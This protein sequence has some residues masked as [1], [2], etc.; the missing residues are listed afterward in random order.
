MEKINLEQAPVKKTFW[1]YLM[2]ALLMMGVKSAFVMLDM[3]MVSHGLGE[4]ALALMGLSRPFFF[5]SSGVSM[6]IG[7]GGATIMSVLFGR[8]DISSGQTI[9][10]QSLIVTSVAL[11]I[12]FASCFYFLDDIVTLMGA[13]GE[14][15]IQLTEY[16][17]VLL[18]WILFH[19]VGWVLI[20]FIKND[21]S[22]VLVMVAATAGFTINIILDYLFIFELSWGIK[23]AAWAAGLSQVFM[24]CCLMLHFFMGKS[25][26]KFPRFSFIAPD[27]LGSIVKIGSPVLVLDLA[28][29]FAA[30]I[31]NRVLLQQFSESNVAAFSVVTGVSMIFLFTMTSIGQA[32][33]PLFSFYWG[34]GNKDNIRAI[35]VYGVKI[36]VLLG[37]F[38]TLL[39]LINPE[40][41][42][43]ELTGHNVVLV[44]MAATALQLYFLGA[45]MMG[46]NMFAAAFFQ[47][48]E[49]PWTAT[50]ISLARSFVFVIVGVFILPKLLPESGIWSGRR[51]EKDKCTINIPPV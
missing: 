49:M 21:R 7:I 10:E 18:P 28:G 11:I 40:F 17:E 46:L 20:F 19:G 45:V 39:T 35:F 29:A 37:V 9:F 12:I 27:Q 15:A 2:P 5:L 51:H 6:T 41:L 4:N 16:L 30:V 23:G 32:T 31:Y 1:I 47:A 34:A 48:I 14:L 50:V 8:G 3:M 33:Q 43:S 38:S 13:T 25:T 22:S 26:L 24:F 42:L 44:G 36:T